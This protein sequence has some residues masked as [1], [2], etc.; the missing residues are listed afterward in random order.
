MTNRWTYGCENELADIPQDRPLLRG[1]GWDRKDVTIVNSNG[2]AADPKGISYRYGGELLTPVAGSPEEL[3]QM[4]EEMVG[5]YPEAKVNYRSNLHIHVRVPGLSSD[6]VALKRLAAFNARWLPELLDL[7]EPIPEPIPL[8]YGDLEEYKG[9]RRR[10][11]RRRV[12]HHTVLRGERLQNQL[13]AE[14]IEKFFIEEVPKAKNNGK[15]LWHLQP[16]QAVNIRQLLET[17]TIEFR[18]FPGTLDPLLLINCAAWC[19][20]YLLC[21]LEGF[22][23]PIR[24]FRRGFSKADTFP[25]FPPYVHWMEQRYRATVHDGTLKREEIEGN[26]EKILKGEFD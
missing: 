16:R 7:V 5:Y 1:W 22:D 20:E 12:S 11:R 23:D 24:V 17:D 4:M 8:Q 14:T 9:A 19:R 18:H 10:W 26:I 13:N 21:A 15:P 25:E 6:L 3:G 2:I